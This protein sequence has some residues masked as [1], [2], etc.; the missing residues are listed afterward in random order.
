MFPRFCPEVSLRGNVPEWNWGK[1]FTSVG[2]LGLS[3]EMLGNYRGTKC[4]SLGTVYNKARSFLKSLERTRIFRE[5]NS[6]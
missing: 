2:D 1:F 6:N 5:T 4:T 3:G